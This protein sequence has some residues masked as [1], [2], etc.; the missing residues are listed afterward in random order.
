MKAI[1]VSVR[2]FD[3]NGQEHLKA[4]QVYGGEV[5]LFVLKATDV[6]AGLLELADAIEASESELVSI[7]YAAP[8]TEFLSEHFDF[9]VDLQAM[10]KD[11]DN[12]GE[13][14]VSPVYSYSPAE[15][16]PTSIGVF[17]GLIDAYDREF[18]LES[19]RP[20]AGQIG[21]A[22][23]VGETCIAALKALLADL[24]QDQFTLRSLEHFKDAC[25]FDYEAY[26]HEASIKDIIAQ[27]KKEKGTLY[28]DF[29][30]Y[31]KDED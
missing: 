21:W 5:R 20:Y 6:A 4:G 1:Y 9:D 23:S 24:E 22:V 7:Q 18:A 11:A 17:A 31:E 8:V 25:D 27:V 15:D 29:F 19:D 13:I 2:L 28:S 10:I 26:A 30:S 3:P 12:L 14:C 16:Q